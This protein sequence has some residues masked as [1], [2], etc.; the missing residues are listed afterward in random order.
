MCPDTESFRLFFFTKMCLFFI[1]V[2][3]CLYVQQYTPDF[4]PVSNSGTVIGMFQ[5]VALKFEA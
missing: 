3:I 5:Q 2:I 4:K 1:C